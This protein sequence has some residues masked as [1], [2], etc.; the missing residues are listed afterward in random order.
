[1]SSTAIRAE[2]LVKHFGSTKALYGVDVEV[3]RGKVLGVLGPNGAGKT[4]AVRVLGTL[5]RPDAG[6]AEVGGY[7]VV[8]QPGK[9]RELIGLTGQ[10]A[11]VDEDL[12]GRRNLVMIGRLLG[13]SRPAARER[14][15]ELLDRFELTEAGDRTAKT[16]SG[17]M[18]RRLDLAA[19][20]VGRPR[21]LYLD[22]PT[23]GLDPHSRNE[24]WA[25]IRLL[26]LEGST[27]LLTTQYLEEAD[28]LAD[29]IVVFDHGRIVAEGTPAELKKQ[30]GRQSL[31]VRPADP[32][33]LDRVRAILA[34]EVGALPVT[35]SDNGLVSVTVPD[36]TA[37]PAVVRRLDDAGIP[38]IELSLRLPSLDEVF[39]GLTGHAAHADSIS[40]EEVGANR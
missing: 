10:Y 30:S 23:T 14:A 32:A 20:L 2:G 33:H 8:R 16:Y 15:G 27:V 6:H 25:T 26:V 29:S 38:V 3:R 11:S 22:E 39:L 31:D 19:S 7:D 5:L 28:A 17:G 9:V 40:Q 34:Q 24:V 37:M 13:M 4:T 21:I 35:D 36:G 18:R 12:S 1:M